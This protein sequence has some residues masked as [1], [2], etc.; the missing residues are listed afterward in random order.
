MRCCRQVLNTVKAQSHLE[1]GA[2]LDFVCRTLAHLASEME[3]R[4]V[5]CASR[6]GWMCGSDVRAGRRSLDMLT[7]ECHI[8]TTKDAHHFKATD[9]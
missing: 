6:C 3:I 4:C 1:A 7:G 9:A 8:F 5:A 2:P